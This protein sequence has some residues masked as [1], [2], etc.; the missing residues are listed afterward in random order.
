MSSELSILDLLVLSFIDRGLKTTYDLQ[1]LASVSVGM[2]KPVLDRLENAGAIKPA[3]ETGNRGSR[4]YTITNKGRE[5]LRAAVEEF[6]SGVKDPI[7]AHGILE[8]IPRYCFLDWLFGEKMDHQNYRWASKRSLERRMED[9]EVKRRRIL[10]GIDE[11]IRELPSDA[12]ISEHPVVALVYSWMQATFSYELQKA[13]LAT[14]D[15]MIEPLKGIPSSTLGTA[16][17]LNEFKKTVAATTR[18]A[19]SRK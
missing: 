19:D 14:L 3:S 1:S 16:K 12:P 4:P 2:G 10:K 7:P 15:E 8:G 13:Y 18:Q 6:R 17:F 9:L 5:T 11:Q